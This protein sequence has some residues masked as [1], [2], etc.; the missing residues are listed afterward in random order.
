MP[1]KKSG[2]S[3]VSRHK[4]GYGSNWDKLR[5]FV[6][7]RDNGLCQ[8]QTCKSNQRIKQA[9]EVDHIIP[10]AGGGTDELSNLQ[11]INKECHKIK[12]AREQGRSL[13]P[14]VIIGL[15]GFPTGRF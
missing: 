14:K 10:K 1:A 8:C 4:R 12:T 9:T 11:A 6:L 7:R 5:L 2:W 3:T 13:N 15:D